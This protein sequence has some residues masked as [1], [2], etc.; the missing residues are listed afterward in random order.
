MYGSANVIAVTSFKPNL[1]LLRKKE[2][3]IILFTESIK[4]SRLIAVDID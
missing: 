4:S 1:D 3:D 2:H